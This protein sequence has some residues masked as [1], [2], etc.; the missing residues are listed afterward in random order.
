[1]LPNDEDSGQI[2][3]FCFRKVLGDLDSIQL[4]LQDGHTALLDARDLFDAKFHLHGSTRNRLAQKCTNRGKCDIRNH[5]FEGIL[6][7]RSQTVNEDRVQFHTSLWRKHWV[8]TTS[9]SLHV[10]Q[11]RKP[12]WRGEQCIERRRL[13]ITCT[14]V[15]SSPDLTSASA[16]FQFQNMH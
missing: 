3:R 13:R 7:W 8:P 4:Q 14:C 12:F 10:C 9:K 11:L 6:R 15:S 1:M 16:C 2:E 5:S